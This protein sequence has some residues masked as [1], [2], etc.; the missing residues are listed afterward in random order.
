MDKACQ[1]HHDCN[2]HAYLRYRKAISTWL[3]FSKLFLCLYGPPVI[4][5]S[6]PHL[7]RLL[8][9]WCMYQGSTHCILKQSWDGMAS[10]FFLSLGPCI[11]LPPLKGRTRVMETVS[12]LSVSHA[13]ETSCIQ[14]FTSCL[15]HYLGSHNKSCAHSPSKSPMK[16]F[17]YIYFYCFF[18]LGSNTDPGKALGT[19]EPW[20]TPS[21]SPFLFCWSYAFKNALTHLRVNYVLSEPCKGP[22][23]ML[24]C[25]LFG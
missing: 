24:R 8:G 16:R 17:F 4:V 25:S 18:F 22:W 23:K 9:S 21:E 6:I 12:V 7:Q 13:A 11:L 2:H 5:G 14:G 3:L 10:V 15:F 19:A 20:A 1:C